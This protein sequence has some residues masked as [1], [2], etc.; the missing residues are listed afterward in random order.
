[1]TGSTYL[2]AAARER[3]PQGHRQ[4]VTPSALALDFS[5][6]TKAF[7]FGT[8]NLLRAGKPTSPSAV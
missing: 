1:M 3:A 4:N 5:S 2:V 7:E 8:R 6:T